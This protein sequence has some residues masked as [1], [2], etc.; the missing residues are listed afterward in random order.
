[1]QLAWEAVQFR[2]LSRPEDETTI[3]ASILGLNVTPIEDNRALPDQKNMHREVV[4]ANRMATFLDLLTKTQGLGVPSGIIF[5]P[6]PQ[7]NDI[8]LPKTKAFGWAPRSWLSEQDHSFSIFRFSP[9]NLSS[10]KMV[11]T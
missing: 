10:L 5:L 1:M 11:S 4:A 6:R 2:T 9:W 7:S 8:D 3:I